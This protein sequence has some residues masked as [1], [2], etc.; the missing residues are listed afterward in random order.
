MLKRLRYTIET[1][2]VNALILSTLYQLIVYL[3]NRRFWRQ[4]PP[5]PPDNFMPRI[6]VVVPLH[7]KSLDT[8]ALLYLLAVSAPTDQY[9]I[10]LALESEEDPAYPAALDVKQHYP[11][12]VK[13]VISGPAGRHVGKIHNLNAGYQAASGDLIA[14]IDADV[15]ITAE[16]WNA[17]LSVMAEPTIGAAFAPP[18][19]VE[20][21]RRIGSPVPT[22]GEMMIALYNNHARTA[23]LPFAALSHRVKTMMGGFMIF[24]RSVLEQAGGLLHLLNEAADDISL[25]RVMQEN[26][27]RM[28]VIPVPARV[29]PERQSYE[30]GRQHIERNLTVQRA[31]RPWDF[32]AWPFTN[33][34]TVGFM[35]GWITEH[36]GRWW[37]RRTWW[38]FAAFRAALAYE[39]DRIRFGRGFTGAAY[40]QLFMLDTFISPVL[41]LRALFRKSIRWHGRT[42][43]IQQGGRAERVD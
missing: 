43:R 6:S 8:L 34:L 28:A 37:G 41:W 17:A 39:L 23:G 21:E 13:I 31:Y 9:E 24:R 33:P 7:G 29:L 1:I 15:Q 2:L 36:E 38:G 25:A 26:G 27:Q 19:I 16:L 30:E 5:P 10:I 20:P 12:L 22:G 32:L 40:A 18:L 4:T 14:F 3:A 11:Q 35:L 42:Y